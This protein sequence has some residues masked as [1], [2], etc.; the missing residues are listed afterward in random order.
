MKSKEWP[1]GACGRSAP[2]VIHWPIG[3]VC[4]R[5]YI[6]VRAHPA[7]CASCGD[8]RAL[9]AVDEEGQGTCG[10]CAG[11]DINYLCRRCGGGEERFRDG[12]CVRCVAIERLHQLFSG[13]DGS[14]PVL[15]QPLVDLLA[16]V[17]RPRSVIEWLRRDNGGAQV[18][19]ELAAAG[20]E[21]THEA[22]DAIVPAAKV[23][24]L[25]HMLVHADA[26]PERN[27]SLARIPIWLAQVVAPLPERHR[28]LMHTYVHWHLLRRAR[29][30][31]ERGDRFTQ[32]SGRVIRSRVT[33]ALA[34]LQW[35]DDREVT[36]A[37]TTQE[38]LEEWLD[39]GTLTQRNVG[40]FL[41]WAHRRSLAPRLVMSR[42]PRSDPDLSVTEEERWAQFERCVH[43]TDLPLDVRGVGALVL[44]YGLPV[45][46]VVELRTEDLVAD[47]HDRRLVLN[48][49]H[50]PLPPAVSRLLDEV[51]S[52]LVTEHLTGRATTTHLF[53]SLLPGR[54]LDAGRLAGKLADNGIHA[55]RGRN[56]ALLALATRMPAATLSDTFGISIT[57][58]IQWTKR[59]K[60]DWHA[61][62][63][64]RTES[65][66][67]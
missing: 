63:A 65:T 64:A 50:V 3:P 55:L 40:D 52:E 21:P 14:I 4:R 16:H 59:S 56:A 8:T 58:A 24:A 28:Q 44:L 9:I 20:V 48:G 5:C 15:L 27:E 2:P 45:T 49:H 67:R 34:F 60:R 10:P 36:L 62:I 30:R 13:S 35:L 66:G 54:G 12:L 19:R 38:Q 1:C 32:A 6:R 7:P 57:A 61:Y 47:G 29:R 25:R 18:L 22:L 23:N 33:A 11:S 42:L 41:T 31:T 39:A 46:R 51:R 26:L 43:D 53:P 17:D 37:D